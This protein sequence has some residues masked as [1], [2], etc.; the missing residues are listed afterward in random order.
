MALKGAYRRG[1]PVRDC[2]RKA[3]LSGRNVKV[4]Q[5]VND[6][7]LPV[8]FETLNQRRTACNTAPSW[9]G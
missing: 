5:T 6:A 7:T 2:R 4:T 8:A 9:D 3:T 1:H